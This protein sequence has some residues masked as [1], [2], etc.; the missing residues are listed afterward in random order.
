MSFSCREIETRWAEYLYRE[1]E[2]PDQSQF[3]KHIQICPKCAADEAVWRSLLGRFDGMAAADGSMELPSELVYRVKRQV[4]LYEDWSKQNTI[5]IRRWA[6]GF[7]AT[8]LLIFGGLFVLL[9]RHPLWRQPKTVFN[10]VAQSILKN[11]YNE[12]TLSI[13]FDKEL[14]DRNIDIPPVNQ[15]E[16]SSLPKTETEDRQKP[17]DD[18]TTPPAS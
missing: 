18:R 13:Y 4:R 6:I 9:D 14:L 17:E 3:V 11:I 2:E 5:Q 12:E 10:P 7:A 1:L 16:V 8:C 15:T